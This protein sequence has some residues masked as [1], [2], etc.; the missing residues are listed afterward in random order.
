VFQL[1]RFSY[2]RF[3][4]VKLNNRV[5]VETT[6]DLSSVTKL[7]NHPSVKNP[8]YNLVGV[9]NHSGD[10]DFGHYTAECKNPINGKW[11]N[12]N[13]SSVHETSIR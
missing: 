5:N 9:V 12:F 8:I 13:D 4:K 6:L 2:G 11:Y 10:I 1:K 7:S 3:R